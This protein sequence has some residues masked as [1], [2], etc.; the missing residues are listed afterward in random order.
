MRGGMV[1]RVVFLVV[2]ALVLGACG[3]GGDP[4]RNFRTLSSTIHDIPPGGERTVCQVVD[5]GNEEPALVR[6]IHADLSIGSHHMIIYRTDQELTDTPSPCGSVPGGADTLLI[7]QQSETALDFPEEAGLHVPAHQHIRIEI[8][9]MNYTD[10]SLDVTGNVHFDLAPADDTVAPVRILFTG[11]LFLALP[12][13]QETT[14]ESFVSMQEDRRFFALTSHTHQLGT[15]A[16]LKR[17]THIGDPNAELLHE[18]HD[19]AE[20]PLD[21]FDPP[22]TFPGADGIWLTCEY[23]NYTDDLVTF[24]PGFDD[25]MC[26][27]WAYWY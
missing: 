12:A 15:Y 1:W 25:E 23:D 17:A 20:P 13:R 3:D 16:S 2:P 10:A 24:G 9:Y 26:F 14:I 21:M 18:S 19:W 27:L 4:S 7:A 5:L 8:H 11:D 6:A 22:L